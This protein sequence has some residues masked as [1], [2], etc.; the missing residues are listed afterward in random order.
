MLLSPNQITRMIS[1]ALNINSVSGER[2]SPYCCCYSFQK[3][4]GIALVKNNNLNIN[5]ISF[6]KINMPQTT[7]EINA[8]N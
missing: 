1:L 7:A 4:H 6:I 8:R 3:S 2:E 5:N